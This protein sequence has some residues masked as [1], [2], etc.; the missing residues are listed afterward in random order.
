MIICNRKTFRFS[1]KNSAIRRHDLKRECSPKHPTR[2]HSQRMNRRPLHVNA[3]DQRPT[4]R[5]LALDRP[6]TFLELLFGDN[7][8]LPRR[9]EGIRGGR[10]RLQV[11]AGSQLG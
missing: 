6:T 10:P 2:V 11:F 5:S 8:C 9:K 3:L 4:E 7:L 1:C